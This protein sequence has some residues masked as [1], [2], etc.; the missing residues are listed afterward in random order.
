M[1]GGLSVIDVNGNKLT[2]AGYKAD[3]TLLPL[4]FVSTPANPEFP[5]TIQ[6]GTISSNPANTF[7]DFGGGPNDVVWDPRDPFI[8]YICQP[9]DHCIIVCNF[10]SNPPYGPSNPL[11]YRYAGYKGG[12]NGDGV[13]GYVDGPALGT[14]TGGVQATATFTGSIS[15]TTLTV[16]GVTGTIGAGQYL[17]D[18]GAG[19]ILAGTQI[20]SG[21]GASWTVNN[22]QTVSSET[23]YTNDGAQLNGPYSI[24]MQKRTDVPGHPQGTMYVADNYNCLIRVIAPTSTPGIAGDVSTLVG[25]GPANIPPVP[26][27]PSANVFAWVDNNVWSSNTITASSYS[28]NGDGTTAVVLGSTPPT[29]PAVAWKII[30]FVDGVLYNT[31][32]SLESS[33]YGIHPLSAFTNSTH[34]S[35]A[36]PYPGAGHTVAVEI[37]NADKYSSPT[38]VP[39]SQAYTILP[40]VLRMTSAGDIVL[41]EAWYNIMARRIWLSGPNANTITR[42]GPTGNLAEVN[43][44]GWGWLDCDDANGLQTLGACGPLDDI[45][46][47]KMDSDPGSAATAWRWSLD[48]SYN[49]NWVGQETF[50]YPAEGQYGVG[51]YPWAFAFSETQFRM[52][53]VGRGMTGYNGWRPYRYGTDPDEFVD[54]VAWPEYNTD[55]PHPWSQGTTFMFPFLL[56]PSFKALYGQSG[57]HWFGANV[58]PTLDDLPTLYPTD[59]E[60]AAFIQ[61]GAGGMVPRPEL[62]IDDS[63][64]PP[65]PGRSLAA[66]TYFVRRQSMS[67]SFPTEQPPLFQAGDNAGAGILVT[68][69][70]WALDCIRPVIS[71]VTVTR[72]SNTSIRVQW[73]TDKPTIGLVAAST[74]NSFTAGVYPYNLWSPLETS[75]STSHD[76]TIT[77]LPDATQSGNNPTHINV[78]SKDKADNWNCIAD[79][80]VGL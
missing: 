80:A 2:I 60:L 3:P 12:I 54:T 79:V 15:G 20:I 74:N 47:F 32:S 35:I 24:Q 43:S 4:D 5:H 45:V 38:Q 17:S 18:R 1:D 26:F 29:V 41:G 52:L 36:M 23:M 50:D 33:T 56:R 27:S 6:V 73:T 76:I 68:P 28:D 11:C 30:V 44:N 7:S 49:G 8:C 46:L 72:Q 21:S 57:S 77:G 14:V 31:G 67:G 13:G 66:A 10:H 51:H 70:T 59:A 78:V 37:R 58:L 55:A 34:F 75:F 71:R 19:H 48:G 39:F 69:N 61:S 62:S 9:L 16:S 53:S 63:A 22:P 25:A 42:I 65:Q 64:S 40:Q